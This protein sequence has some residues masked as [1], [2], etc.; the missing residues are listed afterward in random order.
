MIED[1][2]SFSVIDKAFSLPAAKR[3]GGK[4]TFLKDQLNFTMDIVDSG[5]E[6]E[7]EETTTKN[8]KNDNSIII[9]KR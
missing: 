9:Q 8:K 5:G 3:P 6:D 7:D 4:M 1:E 2:S